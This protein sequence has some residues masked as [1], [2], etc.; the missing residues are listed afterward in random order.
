MAYS[1]E[2]D[3]L[4]YFRQ[5]IGPRNLHGIGKHKI[6]NLEALVRGCITSQEGLEEV[7][8]LINALGK[9]H[10]IAYLADYIESHLKM[11]HP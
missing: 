5:Q 2:R 1:T 9:N 7:Y 6:K 3:A 10:K 8:C 11:I 4:R